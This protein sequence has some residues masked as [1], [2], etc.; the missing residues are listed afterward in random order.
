MF[1]LPCTQIYM[2]TEEETQDEFYF[3]IPGGNI[4]SQCHVRLT[5]TCIFPERNRIRHLAKQFMS[6]VFKGF[7]REGGRSSRGPNILE[8]FCGRLGE[9][10]FDFAGLRSSYCQERS[11]NATSALRRI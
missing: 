9:S 6:L 1:Y 11:V 3:F 8:K 4:I 2:S 7:F 10:C 5:S